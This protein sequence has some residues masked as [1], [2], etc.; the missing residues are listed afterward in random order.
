M[1]IAVYLVEDVAPSAGG[2]FSY[3]DRFISSVASYKFDDSI[4]VCFAGR[5]DKHM[6]KLN[7]RY[8]QLTGPFISN[9][10][11]RV[12]K[13]GVFTFLSRLTSINF[14]F[15]NRRDVRLLIENKVDVLLFPK[16][17][18]KA[19]EG[20]PFMTMNW[21]AGHKSTFL[22]PEFLDGYGY[23]EE[24]YR[25][26]IQKALSVIV[27]SEASRIEYAD[28]F[29]IPKSKLDVV[30]LFPGGVIDIVI[31]DD[32]NLQIIQK[33]RLEGVTYF[34]Y[35][36]QFWAHKNHYNL[37]I[38]FKELL[39]R[40]DRSDLKLLFTGSD[41][42]N[43]DYIR[44]VVKNLGLENNVVI[45]GFVSNEELYA[46]YKNALALV[47]PT[48]LGP[49]NMPVLEATAIGTAVICSDLTG[50]RETCGDGA[51]YADPAVPTQ[52]TDA[53]VTLLDPANRSELVN[54]ANI[55]RS[56]SQNSIENAM[57]HLERIFIKYIPIRKT[58]N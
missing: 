27:E 7:K 56:R 14:D 18:F 21:D 8:V 23:R 30:P 19:V 44:S 48:F 3:Y 17:F 38:A 32:M 39:K 12:R 28:F 36:A 9:V 4:E 54:K 52:W 6:V 11:K 40:T 57:K 55:V 37:I 58:F 13:A 35:P 31:T 29:A 51:L 41:K 34:F 22:F 26:D 46:L 49:T 45:L 33:F 47:M 16:Q 1:K 25:V 10:F 20:Y 2:N 42:G 53:M 50:H 15:C 43:K 5:I 24:W